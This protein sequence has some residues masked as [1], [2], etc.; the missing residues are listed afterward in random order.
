MGPLETLPPDRRRDGQVTGALRGRPARAAKTRMHTP[1]FHSGGEL[2]LLAPVE[3]RWTGFEIKFS[4]SPSVSRRTRASA[5]ALGVDHLFVV[6]P[7]PRTYQVT[8]RITV[9]PLWEIGSLRERIV[10][11]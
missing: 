9:V 10:S 1:S 3:G 7:A 8:E 5:D 6:C 2:D 11:A 4:E